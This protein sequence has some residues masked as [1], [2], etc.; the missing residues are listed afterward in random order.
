MDT[1]TVTSA[2]LLQ[3]LDRELAR[4]GPPMASAA[5]GP[6][7]AFDA[8]GTL[9]SG[10][11]GVDI[12]E[13]LMQ[14]SGVREEARAALEDEAREFGIRVA[15]TPSQIARALDSAVA[16]D[17]YPEARGLAMV[18]WAFAGWDPA[19]VEGFAREVVATAGVRSRI[20]REVLPLLRWA[21]ARGIEAWIVSAS[22]RAMAV[23]AASV[24][25]I[26]PERV[27][28]MT[29]AIDEG[30]VAPRLVG[31]VTYGDGKREALRA[32]RPE[33][34]VLGAFGD[35][36]YDAAMLREARIPVAVYPKPSLIAAARSIPNLVMLA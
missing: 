8:D 20:H 5:H 6:L 25:G 3:R 9:W 4:G 17:L 29:P 35:S 10:D 15:G 34:L 30:R 12:F 19:E 31:P 28:A 26:A 11:I 7:L 21:E 23:A 22:P 2:E 13:A 33:A 27:L 24:V 36:V 14:V 1:P 16:L 32:V 18:A